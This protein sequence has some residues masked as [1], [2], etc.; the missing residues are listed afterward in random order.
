MMD[1]PIVVAVGDAEEVFSAAVDAGCEVIQPLEEQF[2]GDKAGWV[3]DP[4]GHQW[5]IARHLETLSPDE[6]QKRFKLN[7]GSIADRF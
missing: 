6:M 7:M 2:Y 1:E 3:K 5:I 4:F